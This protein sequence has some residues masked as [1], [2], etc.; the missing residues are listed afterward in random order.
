M[1][2]GMIGPISAF[3]S[4][5]TWAIGSAAYS[6]ISKTNNPLSVNFTRAMISLPAFLVVVFC[7]CGGSFTEVFHL[8]RDLPQEKFTWFFISV[9]ASYGIGDIFFLLAARH[10]GITAALA[11]ASA[12][13]LVTVFF[14]LFEGKHLLPIQWFGLFLTLG[15][16]IW[17]IILSH[18]PQTVERAE[19]E[20]ASFRK[21][22]PF[23][24]FLATLTCFSWAINS[25]SVAKGAAGMNAA[26][27][28]S[29]R[30]IFAILVITILYAIRYRT[31]PRFVETKVLK[32]SWWIFLVESFGG[33]LFYVYGLSHSPLVL[34]STLSA[35]APVIAVPVSVLMRLEKFSFR[36]TLAII[37]VV[38]GIFCLSSIE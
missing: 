36:K 4:S 10:I 2:S 26:Q 5:L 1:N 17:V 22:F 7:V 21:S 28:N 13:P 37:F 31:L 8:Y 16:V 12:Y 19:G 3:L 30:M 27:G 14:E 34:A 35:L 38:V 33:S 20:P 32:K 11:I 25:L 24:I 18:R 23:G 29:I 15:S 6:R 9:L